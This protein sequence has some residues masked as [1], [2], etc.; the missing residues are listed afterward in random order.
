[1]PNLIAVVTSVSMDIRQKNWASRI[2]PFKVT[3]G[4]SRIVVTTTAMVNRSSWPLWR[5]TQPQ[6]RQIPVT[7]QQHELGTEYITDGV[8]EI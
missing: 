1:M 2:P 5:L 4:N 6:T 7:Q 8:E 3:Q